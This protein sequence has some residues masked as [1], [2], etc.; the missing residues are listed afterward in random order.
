M[1]QQNLLYIIKDQ[2]MK[3]KIEELISGFPSKNRGSMENET[4]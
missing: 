4:R 2:Q 1:D 3:P